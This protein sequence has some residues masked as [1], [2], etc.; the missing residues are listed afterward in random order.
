MTGLLD[1]EW[2]SGRSWQG[3]RW[4]SFG[5]ILPVRCPTE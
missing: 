4:D 2:D 1:L 3:L 5:G